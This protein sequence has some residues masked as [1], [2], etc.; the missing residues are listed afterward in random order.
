MSHTVQVPDELY[1]KLA[2]YAREQGSTPDDMLI[3]WVAE[4]VRRTEE[5]QARQEEAEEVADDP[6]APFIGAFT[7]GVGDLAERHDSYL[8]EGYANTRE[9]G[10]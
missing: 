5:R 4:I 1:D 2:S 9:P 7:F 6:I 8:A 10:E 3:A